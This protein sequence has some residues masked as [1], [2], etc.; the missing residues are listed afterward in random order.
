MARPADYQPLYLSD[1]HEAV[2]RERAAEFVSEDSNPFA[3]VGLAAEYALV[4]SINAAKLVRAQLS[5][6]LDHDLDLFNVAGPLDSVLRVEVKTRV[7]SAGWTDPGRFKWIAV[8]THDGRE[9]IK[10]VDVVLFCWWSADNPRQLWLLGRLLGPKE[11]KHRATFYAEGEV[12][13]R[14]GPAPAGGTYVL[15]VMDLRPVP[16]GLVRTWRSA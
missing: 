9:P 12:T 10:N 3:W 13:P 11:F 14:G 6:S 5:P 8:P 16:R 7:A 15:D 4:S 1:L 2:A